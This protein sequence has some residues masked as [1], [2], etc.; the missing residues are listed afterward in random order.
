MEW[1]RKAGGSPWWVEPRDI[2]LLDAASIREEA[3]S[4]RGRVTA[5]TRP[6][7]SRHAHY[8]QWTCALR[9]AEL[10]AALLDLGWTQQFLLALKTAVASFFFFFFPRTFK[11]SASIKRDIA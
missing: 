9:T 11:E 10:E 4:L 6:T 2:T 8:K 1:K 7:N 3:K 5:D